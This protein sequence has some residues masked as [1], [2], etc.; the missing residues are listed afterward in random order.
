M[1]GSAFTTFVTCAQAHFR[2]E[3][4]NREITAHGLEWC[5]HTHAHSQILH[6]SEL[7]TWFIYGRKKINRYLVASTRRRRHSK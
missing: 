4:Q 3:K 1:I 7:S 5:V 2:T 6:R